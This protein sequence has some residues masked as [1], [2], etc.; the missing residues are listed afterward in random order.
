MKEIGLAILTEF[1]HS[2]VSYQMIVVARYYQRFERGTELYVTIL[3]RFETLCRTFFC[4]QLIALELRSTSRD[5]RIYM[6]SSSIM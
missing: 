4:C 5:L 6:S 1:A 2:S 3:V